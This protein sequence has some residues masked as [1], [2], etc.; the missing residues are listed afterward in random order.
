M[1]GARSK[2]GQSGG[3]PGRCRG[4]LRAARPADRPGVSASTP[5][6][7]RLLPGVSLCTGL[8]G[9]LSQTRRHSA[10]R[11]EKPL[12]YVEIAMTRGWGGA[13]STPPNCL[14][15]PG[16]W[17]ADTLGLVGNR[18]LLCQSIR[19]PSTFEVPIPLLCPTGE[20]RERKAVAPGC[21]SSWCLGEAAP[22]PGRI[23]RRRCGEP[24][25]E[26]CRQRVRRGA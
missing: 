8:S 12:A 21:H 13:C 2:L 14:H 24:C 26:P 20:T 4:H 11:S 10:I 6:R 5:V 18:K 25:G 16:A 22:R 9:P 15:C 1:D 19:V 23:E 7:G 3:F 17:K